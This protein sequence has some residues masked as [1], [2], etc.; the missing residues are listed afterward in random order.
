M[1]IS[2]KGIKWIKRALICALMLFIF[3]NECRSEVRFQN[4]TGSDLEMG[5]GARAV[6][7]SGA[8]VAVADDASAVFWNPSGLTQLPDNELFLSADLPGEISSAALIYR[9]GFKVLKDYEFTIG[10][11]LV[12][13]LKFKGDSGSGTWEGR[14][15]HLLDMA[16][17][18]VE[19]D[20]SGE[21]DSDTHDIRL[22]LAMAPGRSK[23]FS[24]GVNLAY[25]S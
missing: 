5:V 11:A 14:P 8:F 10:L 17:I 24:V 9:P 18:E 7:L 12:K 6:G 15:S 1:K 21:I 13:R 20:F 2:L 4:I 19:D 16:M 25:I 23:D 3:S 22:S